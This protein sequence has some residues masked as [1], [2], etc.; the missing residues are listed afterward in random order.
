MKKNHIIS[1]IIAALVLFVTFVCGLYLFWKQGPAIPSTKI[2]VA[3]SPIT[4][5]L[6]FF[7]AMDEGYFNDEHLEV[8]TKRFSESNALWQAL[9]QGEVDFT[10]PLSL[11]Q[12]LAIEKEEP[13]TFLLSILALETDDYLS[14]AIIVTKDS[15]ITSISELS[16][17]T[18]GTYT[19]ASA[20]ANLETILKN[21]GIKDTTIKTQGISTHLQLLSTKSVDA[22]FTIEPYITIANS[23]KV[24][25][26]IELNPRSKWII[27]PFVVGGQVYLKK[28]F[29]SDSEKRALIIKYHRAMT[30]AVNDINDQNKINRIRKIHAKWTN[31]APDQEED[32]GMYKWILTAGTKERNAVEVIAKL[33]SIPE[34]LGEKVDTS[35]MWFEKGDLKIEK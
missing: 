31:L 2:R 9:R 35:E 34:I 25:H 22:L 26:V 3:F 8:E 14:S 32:V 30:R 11:T 21:A 4:A 19:S 7:V 33:I 12:I 16:G 1:I 24:G 10:T 6:P 20:K 15:G 27:D 13:A 18:I 28:D 29:D 5:S 17:K 23:Q